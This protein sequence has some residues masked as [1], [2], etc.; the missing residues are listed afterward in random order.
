[1]LLLIYGHTLHYRVEKKEQ[2]QKKQN[3]KK[4]NPDWLNRAQ[5]SPSNSCTITAL[6]FA[7]RWVLPYL[8]ANDS[9]SW[10]ATSTFLPFPPGGSFL[11][12]SKKLL[13]SLI[14][15]CEKEKKKVKWMDYTRCAAER[16]SILYHEYRYIKFILN[17]VKYLSISDW[18][19]LTSLMLSAKRTKQINQFLSLHISNQ[20][21]IIL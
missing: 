4:K 5:N 10:V 2:Q 14:P 1:M 12:S 18:R 16:P 8:I 3:N 6:S 15:S 20:K 9:S 21:E 17:V 7:V 13:V 11:A 19:S